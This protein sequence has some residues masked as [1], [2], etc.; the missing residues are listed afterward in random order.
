LIENTERPPS[1]GLLFLN[2]EAPRD[3]AKQASDQGE[4]VAAKTG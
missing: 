3:A 1:G 4:A 2:Y